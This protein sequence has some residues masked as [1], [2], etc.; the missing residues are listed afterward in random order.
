MTSNHQQ[1]QKACCHLALQKLM[2]PR[3][4]ECK[5]FKLI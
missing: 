1:L 3:H 4:S 5:L 2:S